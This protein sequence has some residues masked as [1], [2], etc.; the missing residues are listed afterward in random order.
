MK[1]F[2]GFQGFKLAKEADGRYTAASTWASIPEWEAWSLSEACRRSHLPLGVW[3]YVPAKG[4]V[5]AALLHERTL[6]LHVAAAC[7]CC[8]LLLLWDDGDC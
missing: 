6:L 7:C 1:G 4:E 3:Q 2:A 5:R 8:M